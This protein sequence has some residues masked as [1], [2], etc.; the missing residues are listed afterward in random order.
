MGGFEGGDEGGFWDVDAID[1]LIAKQNGPKLTSKKQ[2]KV[3]IE[4]KNSAYSIK[5]DSSISI[6]PHNSTTFTIEGCDE[7]PLE[8]N[9]IYKTYKALV[10]LTCDSDIVD[11]FYEHKVVLTKYTP[12]SSSLSFLVLVKELCNL[13]LSECELQTIKEAAL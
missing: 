3:I 6:V 10:E 1:V 7:T 5:D 9:T 8:S 4:T 12:D 2:A 13:V 11:F